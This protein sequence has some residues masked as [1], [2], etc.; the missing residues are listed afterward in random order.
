[1]SGYQVK[2]VLFHALMRVVTFSKEVISSRPFCNFADRFKRLVINRLA[3]QEDSNRG[4]CQ[5]TA[6]AAAMQR[7]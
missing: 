5:L 6:R 1:M 7:L 2:R 3:P 4:A